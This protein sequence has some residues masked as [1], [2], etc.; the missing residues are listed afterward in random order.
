[1]SLED[2]FK[3]RTSSGL[4]YELA[5]NFV[6]SLLDKY[7]ETVYYDKKCPFSCV[8]GVILSGCA[9]KQLVI[10]NVSC[11]YLVFLHHLKERHL[12]CNNIDS[13]QKKHN[14]IL[15]W[16]KQIIGKIIKELCTDKI[17]ILRH[18]KSSLKIK[19]K[20][21]KYHIVVA[22]T[23]SKRQYCEFH[24]IQNNV[25]VYPFSPDQL[26]IAAYDLI[27][28]APIHQRYIEK[29]DKIKY[30]CIIII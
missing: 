28:E 20:G 25:H 26:Q 23:F 8:Y 29:M 21:L 18:S 3:E 7:R 27:D 14:D 24:Y 5:N 15:K 19:W 16:I 1:M 17:K 6:N 9:Q 2:K 4:Y 12:D 13:L 30:D 22:W 10:P 11:G